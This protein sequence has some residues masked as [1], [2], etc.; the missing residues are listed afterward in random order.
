MVFHLKFHQFV[1][2]DIPLLSLLVLIALMSAGCPGSNDQV[3]GED[4]EPKPTAQTPPAQETP[5]SQTISPVPDKEDN[6]LITD[7]A[8]SSTREEAQEQLTHAQESVGKA[9]QLLKRA[10]IGKGSDLALSNLQQELDAAQALL[11]TGQEQFQDQQFQLAR[12]QAQEATKK[13][14][15]VAQHIEQAINTATRQSP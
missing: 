2:Q 10:P 1:R 12:T 4:K 15:A 6:D 3:P 5:E 13:A 9:E 8:P 11:Q 7:T 14:D